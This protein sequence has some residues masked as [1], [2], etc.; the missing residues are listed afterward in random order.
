MVRRFSNRASRDRGS[1]G[2]GCLT[3][4][5][6]RFETLEV[7]M[8]LAAD[9]GDAPAPYTTSLP[10]GAWHEDV[11]PTLGATRDAEAD[12]LPSAL[13]D[14]DGA[15]D[16]GVTFGAKY[17]GQ[18]GAALI[19]NVQNAPVGAQL[20]AWIDFNGD[21]SWGGL[22]EQIFASVG[23][24]EGDNALTFEVPA[25]A[26]AGT[27]FA[28]FRLST[29]GGLGMGGAAPDGEV[30]DYAVT[31]GGPSPSL[32]TF[33]P[34]ALMEPMP[35]F[36]NVNPR[37][38]ATGDIDRDGDLDVAAWREHGVVSWFENHGG[39]FTA[40]DIASGFS[41]TNGLLVSDLDGDGDVDLVVGRADM[42]T[43]LENNGSET[44]TSRIIVSGLTSSVN[45]A[46]A[47]MDADGDLDLLA[48]GSWL[49]ND[50][51]LAFTRRAIGTD[52]ASA[53]IVPADRDRDGDMDVLIDHRWWDNDG[54]QTFISATAL[55]GARTTVDLDHDGDLDVL[56]SSGGWYENDG[57]QSYAIRSAGIAGSVSEVKD[58]DGDGDLDLLSHDGVRV[59]WNVNNGSQS[60]TPIHLTPGT[61]TIYT[62]ASGDID[63]DGAPDLI[64][65]GFV[66]GIG[67]SGPKTSWRQQLVPS[68]YGDAP[69]PFPDTVLQNG[70]RHWAVGPTLGALRDIDANGVHSAA[71]DADGADD[72]GVTMGVMRAG[73][74]GATLT[75]NIQNAPAGARVSAWIDFNGDGHWGG[76]GEQIIRNAPVV[77]GDNLLSFDVPSGAVSGVTYARA[78]LSFAGQLGIVGPAA[79]G[80][81]EDYTVTV[82][83]PTLAA[84]VF[85]QEHTIG[86]D[87]GDVAAVHAAD[88]DGDG[89][90]D[91]VAAYSF[92]GNFSTKLIWF[93][94]EG[95]G[96]F[97][98]HLVAPSTDHGG[99]FLRSL[100]VADLDADGDM[101]IVLARS[102]GISWYENDGNQAFVAH[103]NVAPAV[104]AGSV[105]VVDVNGDGHLDLVSVHRES[106]FNLIAWF[107]N[108][109]Q[110]QFTARYIPAPSRS[111]FNALVPADMDRDGDVDFV[112]SGQILEVFRTGQG[113]PVQ[114]GTAGGISSPTLADLDGDGD[115]D[116]VDLG[117]GVADAVQVT[118]YKNN[119]TGTFTSG[120]I[121]TLRRSG[122]G[123]LAQSLFGSI[124]AADMDGDEDL[125]LVVGA[126]SGG[127]QYFENRGSEFVNNS[128]VF[129]AARTAFPADM[130][131]DGDLD[132]LVGRLQGEVAWLENRSIAAT[133]FGDAPSRYPTTLANGGAYHGVGGPILG[134]QRDQEADGAP[135]A[136]AD[137][138]D[139]DDGVTFGPMHAGQVA[140]TMTVHVE[141]AP[142]GARVDAW[143]DFNGN[144][145]WGEAG[146]QVAISAA[147]SE[148]ENILMFSVPASTALGQIFA[149][150]R[151]STGGDLGFG[152]GAVDGEV[153]DHA[154]T[155]NPPA[156]ATSEYGPYHFAF[157]GQ[158][159]LRTADIDGDGDIDA[160]SDTLGGPPAWHEN[161]GDGAF[162]THGLLSPQVADRPGNDL[163]PVDFDG[164]GD[165]DIVAALAGY[166]GWFENNG[167]ESFAFRVVAGSISPMTVDVA[168]LEG[169]GD[170]DLL[171]AAHSSQGGAR[172]YINDGRQRFFERQATPAGFSATS[173]R[174]ADFDGDGDLDFL[175]VLGDIP[176]AELAWYENDGYGI[177]TP[178]R[179]MLTQFTDLTV[180]DFDGDGD[181]DVLALSSAVPG[182]GLVLL[183]NDGTGQFTRRGIAA[184]P[185]AIP[186]T[187]ISRLAVADVD[188][189]GDH[190][191]LVA[192]PNAV[193]LRN[194]G[195]NVFTTV[196]VSPATAP[197][198]SPS[199]LRASSI[200]AADLNGDGDIEVLALSSTGG[201]GYWFEAMPRGDYDR[202][203][204]V[205]EADRD[206]W[207]QTLGQ[208]VT[209]PGAEAD[210]D[211]SGVV[212]IGDLAV[213]EG[214]LGAQMM[215]HVFAPNASGTGVSNEQIDG[216]DFLAW[217]QWLGFS[218]PPGTT[219]DWDFSGA[220]DAGDLAVWKRHFG[221]GVT[222]DINWI[223]SP[224]PSEIST[225]SVSAAALTTGMLQSSFDLPPDVVL[226]LATADAVE[227]RAALIEEPGWETA[228]TTLS[229]VPVNTRHQAFG[230]AIELSP[231]AASSAQDEADAVR[232]L[233]TDEAFAKFELGGIPK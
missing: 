5:G 143:I 56:Q 111:T 220:V 136:N 61:E 205:E 47:D 81:V 28:R 159:V 32:G 161:L 197:P 180:V 76:D 184:A 130:D 148:G 123:G 162:L 18:V 129:Q 109:G 1:P 50:G 207:E 116:I 31:I 44:F 35:T 88:V 17:V 186:I 204:V 67:G 174:A 108:N 200:A 193:L 45:T 22:G 16:D 3:R 71:A 40:R 94:S 62:F 135:S 181:Q 107:E 25:T 53:R 63:G 228:R 165:T 10:G 166:A 189:D 2:A 7:R 126:G 177:F 127:F 41:G 74:L 105:H 155:I 172:W 138:D 27:R 173:A 134:S 24:V 224:P 124:M 65:S 133:D 90:M 110:Q 4:R 139:G 175:A 115:I 69:A 170:L 38:F 222:P 198:G 168:D 78:R 153:E 21:G 34:D 178:H 49:E 112:S 113:G 152:G 169:D 72:D 158:R 142:A 190:D 160:V 84:G 117:P 145:L 223:N 164:D 43:L 37:L 221:Q 209:P 14:G 89:D 68:D 103:T 80:E 92:N 121:G 58:F 59:I 60:F 191:V 52:Q 95:A 51:N 227:P 104:A 203:G 120:V 102:G 232:L 29:A 201:L 128:S 151:I 185:V 167:A 188:G 233:E 230:A 33:A 98:A 192:Y 132:V 36:S 141:N 179:N 144:G 231:R 13:A 11:G 9:F 87:I 75:A 93:E 66:S 20:D 114:L 187:S 176:T 8:P 163:R 99:T 82:H 19:V 79:D 118:L 195:G 125:D 137:G 150:V 208:F 77:D 147:V 182:S 210:G 206:L 57:N 171:V 86:A 202:N 46:A 214:N 39:L 64:T 70:A 91:A 194:E 199:P 213:W 100:D 183:E 73:Q 55:G 85:D 226:S 54:S 83:P 119:G 156:P 122:S 106:A 157:S 219:N 6:L 218:G 216:H 12:G 212:D 97:V 101:D 217:Q 211:R 26:Q 30:E 48:N 23:V 131:G 42:I 146:E 96:S 229:K 196:N 149:R 140:A 154:V 15:D 225:T 215:P